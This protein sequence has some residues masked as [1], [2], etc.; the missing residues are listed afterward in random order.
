MGLVTE[1][2]NFKPPEIKKS[3]IKK[4]LTQVFPNK[5]DKKAPPSV[6]KDI[7]GRPT[8]KAQKQ[9]EQDVVKDNLAS[10]EGTFEPSRHSSFTAVTENSQKPVFRRSRSTSVSKAMPPSDSLSQKEFRFP[11]WPRQA[12]LANQHVFALVWPRRAVMTYQPVF[13]LPVFA[14]VYE[15]VFALVWPRWAVLT[16]MGR[17]G[18]K[19]FLTFIRFPLFSLHYCSGCRDGTLGRCR[20][21]GAADGSRDTSPL[22]AR[23]AIVRPSVGSGDEV[24]SCCTDEHGDTPMYRLGRSWRLRGGGACASHPRRGHPVDSLIQGS[25]GGGWVEEDAELPPD[26]EFSLGGQHFEMSIERFAV[27]LGIYYEPETVSDDFAHGLTQG[28][29][30]VMRAWWAQISDTPFIGH[31]VR[32]TMIRDPLIKY[33]HRCILTTISG[34]GQSQ[35][36]VTMTDLF[37]LH[38]LIAGRPC[39]LARYLVKQMAR[40]ER[41]LDRYEDLVASEHARRDGSQLP[42][43]PE[44]RVYADDESSAG[45]SGS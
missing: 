22:A 1:E 4:V 14:L 39:N 21:A 41:R 7:R 34:R 12:V 11:L 15:P 29:D 8:L 40:L 36:W 26:I 24:P 18:Q 27:H 3:L 42:P 16:S 30:G 44:P 31:R 37:Y 43:F 45:P 10:Q 28:E 6:Q 17:L 33:I 20:T 2:I 23:V 19:L 5:S 25:P 13:A 38:S 32:A 35:G 9:K